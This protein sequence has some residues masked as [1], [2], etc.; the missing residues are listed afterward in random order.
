ML[1]GADHGLWGSPDWRGEAYRYGAFWPGLMAGW[2]PLYPLQP[3][4][5]YVSHGFLHGG[6][7]HL[8][9]NLV[10]LCALGAP[11]LREVG[12]ARFLALY[13][14]SLLGG[15]AAFMVLG[16]LEVPM[17]GASGPLFGLAGATVA[18]NA[19]DVWRSGSGAGAFWRALALPTAAL[20]LLNLVMFVV[21]GG[22]FAWETHLG[23]YV[24]GLIAAPLLHS[25]TAHMLPA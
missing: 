13:G 10:T 7:I 16:P 18:F 6:A 11:I 3:A 1:A 25:R 14:V 19:C 15:G 8:L 23:G 21:V 4:V 12:C 20:V 2:Q 17:V 24:T 5:M 9:F 22:H